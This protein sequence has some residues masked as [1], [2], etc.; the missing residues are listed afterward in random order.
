MLASLCGCDDPCMSFFTPGLII[1]LVTTHTPINRV[2]ALLSIDKLI[3]VIKLTNEACLKQGIENPHIGLLALNPHAGEN[4]L[5]GEE[6][7]QIIEPA[8]QQ[9]RKEGLKISGPLVPDT[10]FVWLYPPKKKAPFDAYIAMYHDQAL[11]PFKMAAFDKGVNVTLGLP[12]VRTS[13]DHGTAFD[14]AWQGRASPNSFFEA[15]RLAARM[16]EKK[17]ISSLVN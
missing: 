5:F 2:S 10:A 1:S 15:I 3:R 8:I 4:S 11:I 13:P 14:L 17:C 12:M 9:A 16:V 7:L 6:E